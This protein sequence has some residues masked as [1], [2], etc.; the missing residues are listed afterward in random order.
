MCGISVVPYKCATRR[1]DVCLT[2]K[3]V[4]ALGDQEH[5]LNKRTEIHSKC[6]H[7]NKSLIKNVKLCYI[8]PG[9]Q[10]FDIIFKA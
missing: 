7:R 5:L 8:R 3:Y 9:I 10:T 6:C 2:G 4:I 1:C